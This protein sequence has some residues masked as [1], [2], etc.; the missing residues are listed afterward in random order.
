MSYNLPSEERRGGRGSVAAGQRKRWRMRPTLMVLEDRKLLSTIVVN[1]ATDTPVAGK[2]DLR[3]AIVKANTSGG[4][5]DIEFDNTVF[6]TQKTITLSGKQL[7]VS[8]KTGAVTITGPDA[9]VI[10]SAA[11]KSRVF[12]IDGGANASITGLTITGGK[13]PSGGGIE[14][15]GTLAL[16]ADV[17]TGNA[18]AAGGNGGGAVL[19]SGGA[20]SLTI[21][22]STI[23]NNTA[24]FTGGGIC[25]IDGGSLSINDSTISGNTSARDGGGITLQS[26]S[27]DLTADLSDCTISG[28]SA[29]TSG[30]GIQNVNNSASNS[31]AV[32]LDGC[33]IASNKASL[34]GGG[35]ANNDSATLSGCTVK[36]NSAADGGG[37]ANGGTLEIDSSNLFNNLA[38]TGA[39]GGL[40][41]G[42]A[43]FSNGGTV[44]L[45]NKSSLT[46]NQAIGGKGTSSV[47]AGDGIGGGLALEGNST[48]TV[49]NTTMSSNSARGGAG[50]AGANGGNGIGGAIAVA[51]G[52]SSDTSSL[53][54][55]GSQ[56]KFNIARG[57]SG[58]SGANG[59]NGWGGGV[60]FGTGAT[61]LIDPSMVDYLVVTTRPWA[62]LAT[63]GSAG[64]G[65]GGGLYVDHRRVGQHQEC[66]RYNH[67]FQHHVDL[68]P[69]QR[70][71]RHR[72][73][74]SEFHRHLPSLAGRGA[75]TGTVPAAEMMWNKEEVRHSADSSEHSAGW[76][77]SPNAL[78]ATR[79][80]PVIVPVRRTCGALWS[81]GNLDRSRCSCSRNVRSAGI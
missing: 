72:D 3:Q 58:G 1:N 6:S 37:I 51:I 22:S 49:T 71:L 5:Q 74:T 24:T 78:L 16:T 26:V 36:G 25:L 63:T 14:N 31:T 29:A 60:F 27:A 73:S 32:E 62:V 33:M 54:L 52:G 18:E 20:T 2:I 40:A 46:S 11:G 43:I 4:D 19:S 77:E 57:G 42:G 23:S 45:S 8:D 48:A 30:G 9:G 67:L 64:D 66:D 44:A 17:L 80:D 81:D 7:E 41:A 68:R 15:L 38:S 53:T 59:G 50:A 35:L 79:N 28:N 39:G 12:Q 10:V 56:L 61:A 21:D 13:S 65:L 69:Q 34:T 70:H 75:K 47:A 55:T 76:C